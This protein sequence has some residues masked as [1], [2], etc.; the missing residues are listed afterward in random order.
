MWI[1][2]TV[3]QTSVYDAASTFTQTSAAIVAARRKTALPV[4]VP[5]NSRNGVPTLRD[6][7]VRS[8]IG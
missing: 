7:A 2:S 3:D 8:S 6:Q 1:D 5:R 4:S